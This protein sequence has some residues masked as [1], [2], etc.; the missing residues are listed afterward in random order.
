M[1]TLL[2]T[3]YCPLLAIISPTLVS[4]NLVLMAFIVSVW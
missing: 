3:D 1:N 4:K 2:N